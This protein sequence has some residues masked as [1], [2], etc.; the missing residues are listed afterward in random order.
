M[1]SEHQSAEI[2]RRHAR[3]EIADARIL[4]ERQGAT[5]SERMRQFIALQMGWTHPAAPAD[6]SHAAAAHRRWARLRQNPGLR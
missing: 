3:W 1:T 6:D 5:A 4:A 2:R